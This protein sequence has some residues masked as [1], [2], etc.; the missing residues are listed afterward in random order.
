LQFPWSDTRYVL[1]AQMEVKIRHDSFCR[2]EFYVGPFVEFPESV[3]INNINYQ[4]YQVIQY[5]NV[6]T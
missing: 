2:V 3:G 5:V 6:H 1:R 4:A